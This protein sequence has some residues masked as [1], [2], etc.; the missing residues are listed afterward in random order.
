MTLEQVRAAN[1]TFEYDGRWSGGEGSATT[2]SFVEAV[3]R[4]LR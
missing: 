2:A 1:P 3:F 4:S